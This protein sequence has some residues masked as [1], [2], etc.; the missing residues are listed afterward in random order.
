MD[1]TGRIP[2][3]QRTEEGEQ[4]ADATY[5][6]IIIGSG[7]G[8]SVSALRLAEKGYRVLVIEKGKRYGDRP[9]DNRF[10]KNNWRLRKWLWLPSLRFYGILKLTYYRHIGIISGVGVGG[11]SLVYANT[12]PI[13]KDDFFT[14]GSWANL[15]RWQDELKPH[16]QTAYNMLGAVTNPKLFDGDLAIKQLAQDQHDQNKFEPTKVAVYFGEAG[17]A[18]DDPFFEGKGPKRSGCTFCGECMTGCRHNA[19]NTLDKNYLFL[20]EKLGVKIISEQEVTA[21]IPQGSEYEI[22]TKTSTKWFKKKFN[23]RTKGVVLSGGVL[24]TVPLLLKMKKTHLPLLSNRLG[25][26]IRTNSEALIMNVSLDKEK[27]FS[28]GVAIGSIYEIDE[29]TSLEP[30]RYGRGSGFWRTLLM[31]MITEEKFWKRLLK[32]FIVLLKKPLRWIRIYFIGNFAQRTS[33]LLYMDCRDDASGESASGK[34]NKN[35]TATANTLKFSL[36]KFRMKSSVQSGK[37]PTAFIKKAHQ[38]AREHAKNNRAEPMTIASE[39]LTGIPS[40]A[41][42]L[43]GCAMGKH[44][45]EGVIDKNNEVFNYPNMYVCDGSMISANPGVNPSL[46]I[47]AISELAMTRIKSKGDNSNL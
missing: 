23:Y 35:T 21:I 28:K 47:T 10:P 8:G 5:D 36:G 46:T 13:P 16:Y 42:I 31:P 30:V 14:S 1:G 2:L 40:T 37:P 33:I 24:G 20:A 44:E 25:E 19:K 29:N 9:K 43:G 26:M 32:L 41:H 12:L 27:D 3:A 4:N 11:G 22:G 38:L 15:C 6:Y 18:I 7:F 17:I 39:S 34:G 45:N